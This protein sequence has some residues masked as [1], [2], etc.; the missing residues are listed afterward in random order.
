MAKKRIVIE[1]DDAQFFDAASKLDRQTLGDRFI[2]LCLSPDSFH[3]QLALLA[4]YGVQVIS[5]DPVTEAE[6]P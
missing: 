2:E 3:T 5:A 1:V 6:K 4:A